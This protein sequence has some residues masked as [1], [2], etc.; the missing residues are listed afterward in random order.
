MKLKE[1][2]ERAIEL[3]NRAN[4]EINLYGQ[5][6]EN[7]INELMFIVDNLSDEEADEFVRNYR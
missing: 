5:V 4:N 1:V 3:Q 7:T 2:V 6:S